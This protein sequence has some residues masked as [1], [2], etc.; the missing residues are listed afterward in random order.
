MESILNAFPFILAA[1]VVIAIRILAGQ[2]HI[3]GRICRWF[4][5]ISFKL[6]SFVPFMG[7]MSCFIIADT[8]EE[9]AAKQY[10]KDVGAKSDK[11]GE[12]YLQSKIAKQKAE[13]AERQERIR[14]ENAINAA[15]KRTDA[16]IIGPDVVQI[17]DKKYRL[18]SVLEK[19]NI[20]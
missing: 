6:I 5:N 9:K 14:L 4:W 10:H 7:W 8:A 17:G 15:L 2:R 16:K 12:D 20:S 18:G 13:E 1:V 19:L 11:I 3:L